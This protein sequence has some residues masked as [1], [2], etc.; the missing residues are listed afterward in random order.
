MKQEKEIRIFDNIIPLKEQNKLVDLFL[1]NN[2][3]WFYIPDITNPLNKKQNRHALSHNFI[4]NG[5]LNS[6]HFKNIKPIINNACLNL[7]FTNI[8]LSNVR[9]FLQFPLN[10]NLKKLDTPHI[11]TEQKHIVL[12]YYVTDNEA[13]TIIYIG[14]KPTK[15]KPKKGRL[16]K[17][18][19]SLYHTAKQPTNNIRCVINFNI[20]DYE[21]G[22]L[23]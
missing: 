17:F 4:N 18:D 22:S 8:N 7:N 19:G 9:S 16:V 2:F 3:P 14:K 5:N 12:L 10:I 15:I 6:N 11:D 1:G 20:I 13:E 23:S 21:V